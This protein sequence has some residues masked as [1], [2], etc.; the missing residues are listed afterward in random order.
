MTNTIM[1]NGQNLLIREYQNKRVVTF[2][3]IDTVHGRPE[4]TA[5]RNFRTNRN[6]FIEGEDYFKI[7]PDEF[8]RT[9]GNMDLRQSNDV[10][11]LTESGYLMLA[12]SFTDSL[13]WTVQRQ[14]V[15]GYFRNQQSQTAIVTITPEMAVELLK[16]NHGNRKINR[17][18]VRRIADDM[19]TGA[20]K[21]NGE[22][23]KLYEDGSLADGQH[24]LNACILANVPFQTYIIKGI[25]RDV[26]PTIDAGKTRNMVDSLNMIGCK[27]QPKLVPAMNYYFNHATKLTANQAECLWNAYESEFELICDILSGSHHDYIFSQRDFRAFIIHLVLSEKWNE[28]DLRSFISGLKN[29]PTRETSHEMTGY[30][31]RMWYDK[32][33]HNKLRDLKSCGEKSKGLVT[34][35][36]LCTVAEA[37]KNGKIAKSFKW[38][39]QAKSVLD[40][41]YGIAQS[42]FA[43]LNTE[44]QKLLK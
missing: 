22:T 35:D 42:R 31:F 37:Y 2:K 17:A 32:K 27:I 30:Y 28:N 3:D 24:R 40:M 43:I 33:V 26:L 1:I 21:L 19:L 36:A 44:N 23:L 12:K 10:T 20:Y 38:K 5:G 9:I 14:L 25:K 4:G 11:L 16:H 29:K 18:N 34:I 15:N 8:R 39:N 13:A 6:Y 41:G 7:T